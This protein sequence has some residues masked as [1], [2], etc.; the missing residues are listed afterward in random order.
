M[1]DPSDDDA[2]HGTRTIL[3]TAEFV[4]TPEE[5]LLAQLSRVYS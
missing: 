5:S 2:M 3:R 1:A 4:A